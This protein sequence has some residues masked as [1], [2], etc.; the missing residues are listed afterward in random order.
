MLMV[1]AQLLTRVRAR[2][3][4]GELAPLLNSARECAAF[5]AVIA[6]MIAIRDGMPVPRIGQR[7]AGTDK[8]PEASMTA[9]QL[10]GRRINDVP[11]I[12]RISAMLIDMHR[13]IL[14]PRSGISESA[15]PANGGLSLT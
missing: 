2:H 7:I 11:K 13:A 12:R 4:A 8:Q 5:R 14:S 6:D 1:W 15:R 9:S 3:C 10:L